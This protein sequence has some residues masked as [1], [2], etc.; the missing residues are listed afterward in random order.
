M[1]VVGHTI[2]RIDS[3][4]DGR[5]YGVVSTTPLDPLHRRS[6]IADSLLRPGE[7]WIRAQGMREAATWTSATNSRRIRLYERNDYVVTEQVQRASGT[8]LAQLNKALEAA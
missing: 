3:M 1:R 8:M 5:P 6:G 4:P 2:L 7:A